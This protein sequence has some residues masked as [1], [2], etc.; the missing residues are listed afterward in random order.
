MKLS[1]SNQ[2]SKA[3][4]YYFLLG[5]VEGLFVFIALMLIPPDPKNAWLLGYSRSRLLM[6]GGIFVGFLVFMGLYV[7][8]VR[9][10]V[11]L[12]KVSA[13][14]K[15]LV[16]ELGW[17]L[18]FVWGLFIL[19]YFFPYAY[20]LTKPPLHL[21]IERMMPLVFWV[22]LL[23]IQTLILLFVLGRNMIVDVKQEKFALEVKPIK[24]AAFFGIAALLLMVMERF[25]FPGKLVDTFL[26]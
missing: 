24:Y 15:I 12:G 22:F 1:D 17:F 4:I 21:V 11:W 16:A 10:N 18:L 2:P 3:L 7:K 9:N 25:I 6:A 19:V 26:L 8:S 20:Y 14:I 23:C 13:K 5:A